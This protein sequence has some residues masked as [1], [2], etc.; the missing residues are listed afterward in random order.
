MFGGSLIIG[1]IQV[2]YSLLSCICF[3]CL[4]PLC[5]QGTLAIPPPSHFIPDIIGVSLE[6]PC[7]IVTREVWQ[8]TPVSYSA[9]TMEGDSSLAWL[10]GS[11][12]GI[13][14]LMILKDEM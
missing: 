2:Y 13:S 8:I 9:S 5:F 12:C 3:Q 4:K 6:V 7:S 10:S 1:E 14:H 11:L